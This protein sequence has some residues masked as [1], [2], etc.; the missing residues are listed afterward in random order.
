MFIHLLADVY[1]RQPP[2]ADPRSCTVTFINVYRTFINVYMTFINIMGAAC[3]VYKHPVTFINID[4][5][6]LARVVKIESASRNDSIHDVKPLLSCDGAMESQPQGQRDARAAQR[7]E[8][9]GGE[10]I[11]DANENLHHWCS[12]RPSP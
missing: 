4:W 11:F 3:D 6:A 7:R 2:G 9:H 1:K 8:S 12:K 5:R 10:G